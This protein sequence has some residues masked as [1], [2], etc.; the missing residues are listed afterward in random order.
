M[1][2]A[3]SGDSTC[4]Y[5]RESNRPAT[6]S[7]SCSFIWHPKVSRKNV[8]REGGD[9]HPCAAGE[10]ATPRPVSDSNPMSNDFPMPKRSLSQL[11]S[12][13][14]GERVRAAHL[15][16]VRPRK[17]RDTFPRGFVD[18]TSCVCYGAEVGK[19]CCY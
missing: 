11:A 3:A 14:G 17:E 6:F 5:P 18:S 10:L 8:P 7:E 15:A 16:G 1:S 4:R 13:A 9:T 19:F 2:E 12:H